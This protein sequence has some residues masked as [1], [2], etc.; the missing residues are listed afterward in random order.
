L[1]EQDTLYPL[2]FFI[3]ATPISLQGSSGSKE[4]WKATVGEV[5]RD[6]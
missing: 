5:A 4:R 3:A 2:E 1:A 6:G